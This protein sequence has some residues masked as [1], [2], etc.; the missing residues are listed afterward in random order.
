MAALVMT[1]GTSGFGAGTARRL[2]DTGGRLILGARSPGGTVGESLP[3]DL[4]SLDSV[5]GFA[6]AVQDRLGAEPIDALVLNAGIVRPDATGRSLDG[7]E[8]TFSVNHLAPYLL[9]RL[10]VAHL[11][12]GA[13]VVL[14]TSGTHDPELKGGLA[15]PR[16][17]DA[18]L[19]ANPSGD[20]AAEPTSARAGQEAYTASKL[21]SVLTVG[22][23]ADR[24]EIRQRDSTV[25]AYCPG[26][27]FGTGL[28]AGLSRARRIAWRVMGTPVS[29]PV[30]R[31]M[32]TLNT[33]EAAGAALARLA[34][35]EV[36]PPA[37]R[38]YVAL[39]RGELTWPEPSALARSTDLAERLWR[40]S[41]AL[42]G[43]D[44]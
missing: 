12:P 40:D 2:H 41:A 22:A 25:L 14:T 24:A 1:G 43:I 39:R 33:R 13:V 20:A 26:Q 5:R 11:A 19:L 3:L 36:T 44:P 37:G 23:L 30:R 34:L 27:V 32:P 21:C 42:V 17:A 15:P 6:A 38:S 35:G 31:F 4:A 28:A 18:R 8:V 7:H 29:A 9:L 16:H 10:L